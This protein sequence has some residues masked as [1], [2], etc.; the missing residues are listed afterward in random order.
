MEPVAPFHRVAA[1]PFSP[2]PRP[3]Y[4]FAKRVFDIVL[5]ATALLLLLP[6]W[7]AIVLIIRLTSHG[8][9]IF[10]QTRSGKDGRPFTCY[11]FR[12]MVSDAE[13]LRHQLLH[14]NEMSGPV[15]KIRHDPRKTTVGRILRKTSLDELPQLLNVLR[16]DMSIVGPR[17]PLPAEVAEY[18]PHQAQRLAVKPGLTCLWQVSGRNLIDFDEWVELDIA[19]IKRRSFWYDITLILRTIPAVLSTKGAV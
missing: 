4:E 7:V 12:T 15:F 8:P 18:T 19:Y 6:L 10:A 5:S 13:T 14:L 9:A 11:K 3:V 1:V 17:P 16:G 2:S